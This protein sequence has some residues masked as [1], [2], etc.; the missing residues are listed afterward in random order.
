MSE[1]KQAGV[2]AWLKA[3]FRPI[4]NPG[5]LDAEVKALRSDVEKLKTEVGECRRHS[6]LTGAIEDIA[7][8]LKA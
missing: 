7:G 5:E 1:D 3:A 6:G 8:E 2:A 4:F